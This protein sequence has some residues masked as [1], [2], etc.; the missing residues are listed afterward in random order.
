MLKAAVPPSRRILRAGS[1]VGIR[2]ERGCGYPGRRE[3]LVIAPAHSFVQASTMVK[4]KIIGVAGGSGSGKTAFAYKLMRFLGERRCSILHQDS[5]YRDQRHSFDFDG[6]KINFDHPNALDFELLSR[7]LTELKLGK[8]INVPVYDY[9]TH[10]RLE[11]TDPLEPRPMIIL[12]GILVLSQPM[13]RE[14][15]DLKVFI[16][17]PEAVRFLRRVERD[18]RERG[19][20]SAGVEQQFFAH[21]KPMHDLFVEPSRE[22]A[23]CVYSGEKALDDNV[24]N[25]LAQ[26]G[27]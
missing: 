9:R 17:A 27:L 23:D 18:V 26:I 15:I 4:P 13:I 5:Y 25:L 22:H 19:R 24:R 8:L 20:Q 3:G 6:G 1:H 21:V 14:I 16:D 2:F 11:R 10:S 7:H 12:E